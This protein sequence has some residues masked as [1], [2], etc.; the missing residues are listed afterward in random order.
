MYTIKSLVWEE[1]GRND[2][3]GLDD[4]CSSAS[5]YFV[6]VSS[7]FAFGKWVW[8]YEI[9]LTHNDKTDEML[10]CRNVGYESKYSA[11]LAAEAAYVDLV[12]QLLEPVTPPTPAS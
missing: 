2:T 5:P 8:W 6:Y 9:S 1:A 10:V 3:P 4:E 7:D 12:G 11:K